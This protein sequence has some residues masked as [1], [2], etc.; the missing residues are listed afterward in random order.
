MAAS[1]L[2]ST[3]GVAVKSIAF[4][5]WQVAAL[6]SGIAAVALFAF[7]PST[8]RRWDLPTFAVG[9]T[10]AVTMILFVLANKNTTGPFPGDEALFSFNLCRFWYVEE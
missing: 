10:Y 5:G 6:R 8:R 7:V 3:G 9:L 1:A 2:F 4:T